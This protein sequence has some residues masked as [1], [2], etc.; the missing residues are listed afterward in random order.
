MRLRPLTVL[1]TLALLT[2]SLPAAAN[3]RPAARPHGA[4]HHGYGARHHGAAYR[5]YG[6]GYPLVAYGNGFAQPFIEGDYVGEPFTPFPRPNH[7]VPTPWSYGTYGVPTV[8]GIPPAPTGQPTLTV[9][10]SQGGRRGA[11]R[12]EPVSDA[13]FADMQVVDVRVPRR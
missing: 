11:R 9:I 3:G 4:K 6:S 12:A 2:A 5:G 7:L 1:A 13:A 10:H 8:S